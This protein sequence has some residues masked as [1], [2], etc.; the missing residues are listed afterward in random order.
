MNAKT[1]LLMLGLVGLIVAACVA[2]YP[3]P[4]YRYGGGRVWLVNSPHAVWNG[5]LR[6]PVLQFRVPPFTRAQSWVPSPEQIRKALRS[7]PD[8]TEDEVA[9]II[10]SC[11]PVERSTEGH[12]NQAAPGNGAIRILFH[13]GRLGRAV[14]EPKCYVLSVLWL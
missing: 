8:L 1:V 10:R 6:P 14:P 2:W 3:R 7:Y 9:R 4:Y 13:A 11:V 12:P 5:L